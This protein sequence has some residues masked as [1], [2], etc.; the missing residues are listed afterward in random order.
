MYQFN[1]DY[2]KDA[3]KRILDFDLK[4]KMRSDIPEI[5]SFQ[6]VCDCD[7]IDY[8]L[9]FFDTMVCLFNTFN[10]VSTKKLVASYK[11]IVTGK[12]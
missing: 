10:H 9:H 7:D 5:T 1:P 11:P 8:A 2:I 4:V 6:D 12:Q 3:A